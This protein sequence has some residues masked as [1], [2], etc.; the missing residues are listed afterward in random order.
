MRRKDRE[1]TDKSGIEPIPGGAVVCR[2]ALAD[3]NEPCVVPVCFGYGGSMTSIRSA[4]AGKK[5]EMV[6]R[7]PRC[8]V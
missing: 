6:V 2:I 8:C 4:P 3:E 7:N 1:I 5:I